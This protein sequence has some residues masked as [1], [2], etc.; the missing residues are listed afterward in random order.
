MTER[1]PHFGHTKTGQPV[2]RRTVDHHPSA[3]AVQ[4]FNKSVAIGLTKYVGTMWCFWIFCLLSLLS[5]PAVLSAF[6]V[7]HSTFPAVI[8]KTSVIALVAW[9]AQT[10]IQL[11]LL[12]AIMVGQNIQGEASDAR[13]EKTFEDTETII[14]RLN[15]ETQGGLQV[16]LARL[17][18][19]EGRI[20]S[21]PSGKERH[22]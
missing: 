6:S 16:V 7:F 18:E 8:I 4:R 14:D 22:D 12:P 15:T 10:F 21:L 9:I 11:V 2:H 5:L 20:T 1:K 17:A 19:L 3:T 13:A